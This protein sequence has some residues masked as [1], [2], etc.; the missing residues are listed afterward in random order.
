MCLLY[1]RKRG[2]MGSVP[3]IGPSGK[4]ANIRAIDVAFRCERAPHVRFLH[5]LNIYQ[6]QSQRTPVTD[7]YV[8]NSSFDDNEVHCTKSII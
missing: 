1:P 8:E 7:N 2:L 6:Q 3:Y 5:N 4:C